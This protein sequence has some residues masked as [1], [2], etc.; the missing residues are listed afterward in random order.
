M[1]ITRAAMRSVDGRWWDSSKQLPDKEVVIRRSFD[2]GP[3]IL[4]WKP[5]MGRTVDARRVRE[6]CDGDPRPI[7]LRYQTTME[8]EPIHYMVRLEI[9]PETKLAKLLSAYKQDGVWVDQEE[10]PDIVQ[11]ARAEAREEFGDDADRP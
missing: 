7:P 1:D 8:G 11:R 2:I 5:P 6:Y 10:F 4:P 3:E 9:H